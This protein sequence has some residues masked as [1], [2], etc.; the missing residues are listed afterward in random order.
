MDGQTDMEKLL[1]SFLQLFDENAFEIKEELG[2][3]HTFTRGAN[4]NIKIDA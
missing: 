4:T 3:D 1:G 2:C